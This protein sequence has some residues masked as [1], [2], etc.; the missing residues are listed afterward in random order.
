MPVTEPIHVRFW[1]KVH[2]TGLFDCWRW[3]GSTCG[4][5]YG[6]IGAGPAYGKKM[7][8]THRY[9]Y[10]EAYG[11]IAPGLQ[12]DHLCRNRR[13][14]NPAHLEAVTQRENMR[15][16]VGIS[17]RNAEKTHCPQGHPYTHEN[18]F[19]S[20]R[21]QRTCRLCHAASCRAQWAKRRKAAA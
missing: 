7:I 20:K 21:G 19:V 15:R 3:Q 5:G 14:V 17:T 2:V 1:R 12:I 11:P 6:H 8:L 10:E 13:C 16:G 4:N 18:T 9:A